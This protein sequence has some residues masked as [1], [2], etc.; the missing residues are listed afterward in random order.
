MP[1]QRN[2][3]D[4]TLSSKSVPLLLEQKSQNLGRAY[5][6]LQTINIYFCKSLEV[7]EKDLE[8]A[9]FKHHRAGSFAH[10]ISSL[11]ALGM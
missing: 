6:T 9:F 3:K 5:L 2:P 1:A 4:G 7:L 11:E 8:N 10:K